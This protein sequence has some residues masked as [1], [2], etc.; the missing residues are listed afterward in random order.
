MSNWTIERYNPNDHFRLWNRLNES[1][2]NSTFLT[3]RNYMDYHSDRFVD[4]SLVARKNKHS[5]ALLPANL[6]ADRVLHSHQGLTYGGWILPRAHFD[7]VDMMELWAVMTDF[8][9]ANSIRAVDYKPLPAI[10]ASMPSDEDRYALFRCGATL[11]ECNI[12]AAIRLDSM[13]G[14]NE[15]RRRQLRKHANSSFEIAE[16]KSG[17]DFMEFYRMLTECLVSRHDAAPI[18]SVDEFLLLSHRF[19]EKTQLWLVKSGGEIHAGTWLFVSEN[20]VHC[21]YI[22]STQLGRQ[23]NMLTLLFD[24]LITLAKQGYFGS[25]IKYFDF[26]T[27]N[28]NHALV[29]NDNLYRQKASMGASG[30][31]YPR[32]LVEF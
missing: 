25:G 19:P 3:D 26:G 18:H 14:F 1:A 9:K 15:M 30:V 10:Y 12:S 27:S 20:V 5:I 7:C 31:A 16:A 8:C 4:C 6:S 2:R 13:A 17:S 11:T 22:A 23:E 28:E 21:Q 29:L 24:R 32:Y